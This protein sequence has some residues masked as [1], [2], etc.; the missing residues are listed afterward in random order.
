M[1]QTA[2]NLQANLAQ[3]LTC[4]GMAQNSWEQKG[5]GIVDLCIFHIEH[6]GLGSEIELSSRNPCRF[7]RSASSNGLESQTLAT[8]TS[9]IISCDKLTHSTSY[10]LIGLRDIT[11]FGAITLERLMV[12]WFRVVIGVI[13]GVAAGIWHATWFQVVALVRGFTALTWDIT[14]G[15]S[16]ALTATVVIAWVTSLIATT[17]TE[18]VLFK[19][20]EEPLECWLLG[21]GYT[22]FEGVYN[23]HR[24]EDQW[25]ECFIFDMQLLL[26]SYVNLI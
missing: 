15:W 21:W 23:V 9:C 17:V 26:D 25:K 6:V 13:V 24:M 11:V 2:H 12:T 10:H 4:P 18:W 8:G 14:W 3:N 7:F 19:Y 16:Q 1:P 22:C 20:L 5:H